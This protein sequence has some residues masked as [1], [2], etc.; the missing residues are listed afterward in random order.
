MTRFLTRAY[1]RERISLI[2]HRDRVDT[3]TVSPDGARIIS[4]SRDSVV[5]A[6]NAESG[7]ELCEYYPGRIPS[8][9]N[10]A[11]KVDTI[12]QDRLVVGT[13]LGM[14]LLRLENVTVG[15]WCVTGW[16]QEGT[17]GEKGDLIHFGCPLCRVWSEAPA[18]RAGSELACPNCAAHLRLNSFT[19]HGD[20]HAVA[21]AWSRHATAEVTAAKQPRQ[22]MPGR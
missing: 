2:G 21:R 9:W 11:R 17:N 14:H 6:W 8:D 13:P 19:I 4:A 7:A 5:K 16:R 20:W 12:S 22:S 10:W 1:G 18:D 15:S 3:V